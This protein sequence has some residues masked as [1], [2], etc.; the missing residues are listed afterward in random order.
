MRQLFGPP[1]SASAAMAT[2]NEICAPPE[3]NHPTRPVDVRGLSGEL[4]FLKPRVSNLTPSGIPAVHIRTDRDGPTRS[5]SGPG[6]LR[7]PGSLR[8]RDVPPGTGVASP[9]VIM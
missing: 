5:R 9:A 8:F 1:V 7:R 6:G 2:S 4:V 3:V